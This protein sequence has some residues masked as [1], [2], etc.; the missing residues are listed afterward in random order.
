MT[1]PKWQYILFII[2][3]VLNVYN[4]AND[5]IRGKPE[6]NIYHYGEKGD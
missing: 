3:V 2:I 5:V 6:I 1:I 4:Y